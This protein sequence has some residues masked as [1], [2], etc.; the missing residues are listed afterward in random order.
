MLQNCDPVPWVVVSVVGF[1]IQWHLRARMSFPWQN[2]HV[3]SNDYAYCTLPGVFTCLQW[4][5]QQMSMVEVINSINPPQKS[6]WLGIGWPP[7][8]CTLVA[9]S[10]LHFLWRWACMGWGW[11]ISPMHD[12]CLYTREH[13]PLTWQEEASFGGGCMTIHIGPSL[14]R[15]VHLLQSDELPHMSPLPTYPLSFSFP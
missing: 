9:S 8:H 14:H 4:M 15:M 3:P 6:C 12:G 11:Y 5:L 13:Q 1:T 2:A 10:Y 7:C